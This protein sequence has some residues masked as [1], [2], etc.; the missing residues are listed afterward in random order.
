MPT[1]LRIRMLDI[2][3]EHGEFIDSATG[4]Y[5]KVVERATSKATARVSSYLG[6]YITLDAQGKIAPTK[7]NR[8]ISNSIGK[9][10]DKEIRSEGLPVATKWFVNQFPGQIPFFEQTIKELNASFAK[11]L[12][13]VK[14]LERDIKALTNIQATTIDQLE[15]IIT[16]AGQAVSRKALIQ[17]GAGTLNQ[18][19]DAILETFDRTIPQAM[20]LAETSMSMYSRTLTDRAFQYIENKR[21]VALTYS[22]QGP[23]DKVTRPFC[24]RLL[25]DK[26]FTRA[27]IEAMDNGSIPNVFLSCGGYGC[28]HQWLLASDGTDTNL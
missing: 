24:K 18:V 20:S 1:S 8:R 28:R 17:I 3:R 19:T 25:G 22:Y 15:S 16:A 4:V 26:T 27:Q 7:E 5:G 23:N 11:P 9:L 10:L 14:F 2:Y 21:G 6:Q 12:P 13:E